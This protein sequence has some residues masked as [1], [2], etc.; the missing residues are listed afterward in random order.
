[1]PSSPEHG[2]KSG[3]QFVKI[4]S[5]DLPERFAVVSR[6][7]KEKFLMFPEGGVIKSCVLP[8]A[9]VIFKETSL[10]TSTKVILQVMY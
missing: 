2:Y 4:V 9:Q 8:K 5:Q 10:N 3:R 1:M 7:R 6:P